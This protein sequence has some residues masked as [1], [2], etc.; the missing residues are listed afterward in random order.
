[1]VNKRNLGPNKFFLDF[2]EILLLFPKEIM[3]AD[4]QNPMLMKK[5]WAVDGVTKNGLQISSLLGV[6]LFEDRM[7]GKADECI[8]FITTYWMSK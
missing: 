6:N 7:S 4:K 3:F 5:G 1:M 2:D 8:N